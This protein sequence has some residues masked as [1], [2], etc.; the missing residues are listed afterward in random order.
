MLATSTTSLL[1]NLS[2]SLFSKILLI[3]QANLQSV[4]E[5]QNEQIQRTLLYA[6]IPVVVGFSFIVFVIYR[7]KRESLFRQKEAEFKLSLAESELKMLRSQINPHFIFNCMNSIHHYMHSHDTAGAADYLIKFSQLIRHVLET[8]SQRMVSLA[9]EV[10]SLKNYMQ[11]EQLR[12]NNAFEF[13]VEIH[14]EI[15]PEQIHIPP[16]LLQPFI[17]NSIWHGVNHD[18]K[19][20]KINV[21]LGIK[22]DRHVQCIIEDNGTKPVEKMSHDLS[23]V[24]KKTSLGIQ[25]IHQRMETINQLYQS[26]A[27]FM[28]EDRLNEQKQILGKRT[29]VTLPF[30]D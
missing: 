13:N 9:D 19:T 25:L 28:L 24:V 2:V 21:M 12:M 14:K 29:T 22:D 4:V 1:Q 17:E 23:H 8:S 27:G 7:A 10:E 11:L 16:M 3:E 18:G 6:L 5:T 30:E 20:G 15:D 26:E